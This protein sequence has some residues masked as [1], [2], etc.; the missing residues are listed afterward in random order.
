MPEYSTEF[1]HQSGL[2]GRL[3]PQVL[4]RSRMLI[5]LASIALTLSVWRTS[6]L[7]ARRLAEEEWV[8]TQLPWSQPASPT[9]APWESGCD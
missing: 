5:P 8:Q 3:C 9:K 1:K 4:S 2:W 6:R 7:E